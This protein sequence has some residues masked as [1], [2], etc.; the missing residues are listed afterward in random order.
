MPT[1]PQGQNRPAD[2]VKNAVTIAK[3]ATGEIEDTELEYPKKAKGGVAGGK[4][5][6]E[7]LTDDERSEIAKKAAKARWKK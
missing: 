1:G 2:V 3:I 7:K 5:R 6:A 4:K